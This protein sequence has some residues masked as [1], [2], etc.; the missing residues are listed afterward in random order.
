[1][2]VLQPSKQYRIFVEKLVTPPLDSLVLN[3]ELFTVERRLVSDEDFIQYAPNQH[4]LGTP[5][6]FTAK[7]VRT[8]GE[9]IE[10]A[11]SFL[12]ECLLRSAAAQYLER[13]DEVYPPPAV[14]IN[15]VGHKWSEFDEDDSFLIQDLLRMTLMPNGVPGF[16]FSAVG[17]N[18]LAVRLTDLGRTLFGFT[19]EFIA[20]AANGNH[21]SYSYEMVGVAVPDYEVSES[22]PP[23]NPTATIVMSDDPHSMFSHIRYRTEIVVLTDLPLNNKVA[24]DDQSSNIRNELAS[25]LVPSGDTAIKYYS[26][27]LR[28]LVETSHTNHMFETSTRTHNQFKISATDLQNFSVRLYTR[29]KIQKDGVWGEKLEPFPMNNHYFIVQLAFLP[30]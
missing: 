12:R 23:A 19:S 25:Y 16:R 24:I 22:D 30:V 4:L 27:S 20:V 11:N 21:G 6:A 9:L 28:E 15:A 8:A 2:P 5:S 10:Q 3:G 7:N 1:M 26:D 14:L 17:V 13:D 18:M 29:R